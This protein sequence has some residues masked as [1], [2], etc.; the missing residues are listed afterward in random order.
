MV[1][2]QSTKDLSKCAGLPRLGRMR[3]AR[4]AVTIFFVAC[5]LITLTAGLWPFSSP[6]NDAAWVPNANGIRF[7]SRGTAFSEGP[8]EITDHGSKACSLEVWLQPTIMWTT[9]TPLSFYDSSTERLFIIRQEYIDL[10]L[11]LVDPERLGSDGSRSLSVAGVFRKKAF[12]VAIT[13]D[14]RKTSIYVDGRLL[15]E[16]PNFSL[17]SQ[18]LSGRLIL[19]N[20]PLRNHSWPGAVKGLAI[21][22]TELSAKQV[23]EDYRDWT[24]GRAA[25]LATAKDLSAI[26]LFREHSGN[27]IHDARAPGVN[28][29]I[30]EKFVTVDQ[31]HFELPGSEAHAD[32][33]YLG[34]IVFNVVGFMPLGFAAALFFAMF[35]GAR[36]TVVFATLVGATT[37]LAIEYFQAYLPTRYS[38]V[39]DLISNPLGAYVGA[40]IYCAVAKLAIKKNWG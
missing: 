7:S 9:G 30:P 13:S 19:G 26:Y 2:P 15:A 3:A 4:I 31:L 22:S 33:H 25:A 27:V 38:G 20:A 32:G 24:E 23:L 5:L 14:G 36:R 29:Q 16:S 10:V 21:Y 34:N 37:S 35:Y 18:D 8:L 1:S 39:T 28:L 12:L 6:I 11:Q 17:S 40:M